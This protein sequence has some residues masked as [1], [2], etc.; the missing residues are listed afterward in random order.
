MMFYVVSV[1]VVNLAEEGTQPST[2]RRVVWQIQTGDENE[3]GL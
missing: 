3:D 2:A 1:R